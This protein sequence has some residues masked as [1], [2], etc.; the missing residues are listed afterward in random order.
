MVS[1]KVLIGVITSEYARRADFYD[2]YNLLVKPNDAMVIMCH[3]S[4]PANGRN[5]IIDAALEN[6]CTHVLFIDDD[7]ACRPDALLK[8]LEHDVD[9]VSGLYFS[10][11]YPH[12]PVIF[13]L[14]N[15][16]GHAFPIYMTKDTKGLLPIKAA[17]LGF[18]LIKTDVFRKMEKPW[19]RLGE[20]NP[21]HWCD[22]IG[23]FKR[24]REAGI[25]SFVDMDVRV[26][27]MGTMIIWPNFENNE[28]HSMYDTNGQNGINI[29]QTLPKVGYA[30]KE[31]E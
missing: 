16:E 1:S 13:D 14:V 17:G 4:S 30:F 15:D 25:E 10:R 27:H 5:R 7:M 2:F 11:V 22:D 9:I 31:Q 19:I 26:G 6:D 8:L 29:P 24:V 20:L 3:D 23:F 12:A 28:W 21:E 18:V